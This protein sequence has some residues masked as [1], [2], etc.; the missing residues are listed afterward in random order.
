MRAAEATATRYADTAAARDATAAAAARDAAAVW[1]WGWVEVG[2]GLRS[3][4]GD[5]PTSSRGMQRRICATTAG[6]CGGGGGCGD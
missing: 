3:G 1:G 4:L 6:W 5:E 2:V